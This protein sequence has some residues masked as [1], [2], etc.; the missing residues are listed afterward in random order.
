MG[1]FMSKHCSPMSYGT[2][3]EKKSCANYGSPLDQQSKEL[4]DKPKVKVHQKK[5]LVQP[6]LTENVGLLKPVDISKSINPQTRNN[7]MNRI[8]PIKASINIDG[9]PLNQEK[10]EHVP[11]EFKDKDFMKR[12]SSLNPQTR[13]NIMN[14][15]RRRDSMAI[16]KHGSIEAMKKKQIEAEARMTEEERSRDDY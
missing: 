8:K 12:L 15:I 7:I 1:T 5:V 4:K 14:R 6:N 10:E 11:A 16:A 9:T 13:N 3:L 2:P